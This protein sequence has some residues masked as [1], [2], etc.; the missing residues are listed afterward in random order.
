M[1]ELRRVSQ[2]LP[3][4]TAAARHHSQ[5]SADAWHLL[6]YQTLLRT[7]PVP[8]AVPGT[9]GQRVGKDVGPALTASQLSLW[10]IY[11][12]YAKKHAHLCPDWCGSVGWALSCKSERVPVWFPVRACLGCGF[13]PWSGCVQEATDWCSSFTLMSHPLFLPPCSSL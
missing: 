11:T 2:S 12:G 7:S 9:G 1:K 4:D 10:A 13:R 5:P 6:I 8:R 3:P